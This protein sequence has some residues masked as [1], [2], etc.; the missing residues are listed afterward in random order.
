[1]EHVNYKYVFANQPDILEHIVHVMNSRDAFRVIS[2]PDQTTWILFK[3]EY[4][5]D[6]YVVGRMLQVLG[7]EC[8]LKMFVE[9]VSRLSKHRWYAGVMTRLIQIMP[10][11]YWTWDLNGDIFLLC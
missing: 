8:D 7:I 6:E 1:M 9:E 2:R 11:E 3:T 10:A 4:T 5:N